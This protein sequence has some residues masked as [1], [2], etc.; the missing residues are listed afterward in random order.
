MNF[1][2][3]IQNTHPST[4]DPPSLSMM[5]S[6]M[7]IS[8]IHDGLA[9]LVS[10]RFGLETWELVQKD[11]GVPDCESAA[12]AS[13]SSSSLARPSST[14]SFSLLSHRLHEKTLSSRSIKDLIQTASQVTGH[15][16]DDLLEALGEFLVHHLKE[17]GCDQWLS[18]P[19]KSLRDWLSNLNVIQQ[20]LEAVIYQSAK[21]SQQRSISL[22]RFYCAEKEDDDDGS[23]VLHCCYPD[24]KE[25]TADVRWWSNSMIKG[26]VSEV[27]G[28][29]FGVEINMNLIRE[30]K[31][32]GALLRTVTWSLSAA[33]PNEQWKLYRTTTAKGSTS[34]STLECMGKECTC[35]C[36]HT[37]MSTISPSRGNTTMC[38]DIGISGAVARAV[39]PYHIIID[40]NFIIQQVGNQLARVFRQYEA[41]ATNFKSKLVGAPISNFF[42]IEGAGKDGWSWQQLSLR[43]HDTFFLETR[44]A[45]SASAAVATP[46][47]FRST[48]IH[49][50]NMGDNDADGQIL[51]SSS[52]LVMLILN[53]A[54]SDLEELGKQGWTLGDIPVHSAQQELILA[55]DHLSSLLERQKCM[56]QL[57]QSL[58][59]E[60]NL[61]ES[62]LPT[63][64]AEGLRA[65]E[66]V[67]PLSH[68][69]SCTNSIFVPAN[70][71]L[72]TDIS[73]L[74]IGIQNVTFFFSDVVGFT[75]ICHQ[76]FPWQVIEMLNHLYSV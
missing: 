29:Q 73:Y 23:L 63:H 18:C 42:S 28:V 46:I 19:G 33:N 72:V 71:A 60:R 69:V 1:I 20:H 17:E 6:A 65:G 50:S 70:A 14:S 74:C 21:Q 8:F 31:D 44:M 4:S 40:S 68:D 34:A 51:V 49:L 24:Q 53:P 47:R 22:P 9:K 5:N 12:E 58:E 45:S 61:L 36:P 54:A 56:E 10:E 55:R 26:M 16:S 64:V 37:G 41:H 48:A 76:L 11:A 57:G 3:E 52:P 32:H 27:A 38:G 62:L 13:S 75:S 39:F 7:L 59:R 30:Q 2:T 67:Q 66:T 25:T 43:E 35:T 15:S